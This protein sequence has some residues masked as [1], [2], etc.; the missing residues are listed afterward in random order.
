[1]PTMDPK[2]NALACG[3]ARSARVLLQSDTGKNAKQIEVFACRIRGTRVDHCQS[4]HCHHVFGAR[5]GDNT[6]HG[7]VIET[8]AWHPKKSACFSTLSSHESTSS[9]DVFDEMDVRFSEV[10]GLTFE[11]LRKT[12]RPK[13]RNPLPVRTLGLKKLKSVRVGGFGLL[14]KN[15]GYPNP[16]KQKPKP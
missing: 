4:H 12:R 7:D 16:Y 3:H 14:A 13:T 15:S 5:E 10:T 11:G 8:R 1:M 2:G 9:S 6:A